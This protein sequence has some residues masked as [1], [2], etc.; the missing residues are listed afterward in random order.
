MDIQNNRL[1]KEL[2]L[3][4]NEGEENAEEI[5]VQAAKEEMTDQQD[6]E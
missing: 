1:V 4:I 2:N 5:I 3:S 6:E